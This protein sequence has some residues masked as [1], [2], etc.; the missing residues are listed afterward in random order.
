MSKLL[1]KKRI[2]DATEDQKT[3]EE[4]ASLSSEKMFN[5][6]FGNWK[7]V[8]GKTK[9]AP[10]PIHKQLK[11]KDFTSQESGLLEEDSTLENSQRR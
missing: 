6:T 2:Q 10:K 11:S 1:S 3:E 8:L 9:E 5:S 7:P 4:G